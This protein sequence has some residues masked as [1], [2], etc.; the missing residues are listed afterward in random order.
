MTKTASR[1]R[2]SRAIKQVQQTAQD[3]AEQL[4]GV[5]ARQQVK[6]G[7]NSSEHDPHID[8]IASGKLPTS[9][10][11]TELKQAA[12]HVDQRHVV[13]MTANESLQIYEARCM[14]KL[15]ED[16][17]FVGEREITV[18]RGALSVMMAVIRQKLAFSARLLP[19]EDEEIFEEQE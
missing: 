6:P 15:L 7:I 14:L 9:A 10:R 1:A 2:T 5:F 4:G 13:T 17:T 19:L 18:S 11:D 3:N 16:L 12:E 8:A